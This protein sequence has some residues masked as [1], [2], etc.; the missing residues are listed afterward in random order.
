MNEQIQNYLDWVLERGL[1]FPK[2]WR[3]AETKT[4]EPEPELEPTATVL[5]LAEDEFDAELASKFTTLLNLT[6]TM[7]VQFRPCP[8]QLTL[9]LQLAST[10]P[11]VI[12]CFGSTI[13]NWLGIPDFEKAITE[14]RQISLPSLPNCTVLLAMPVRDMLRFPPYKRYTWNALKAA[15]AIIHTAH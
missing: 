9:D 1:K 7:S 15:M 6:P 10:P 13:A 8:D 11:P 14:G 3:L 4:A 2:L 5:F 12:I